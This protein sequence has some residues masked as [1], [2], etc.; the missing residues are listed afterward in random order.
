MQ[1]SSQ[2]TATFDAFCRPMKI[3]YPAP[4]VRSC[5]DVCV[6]YLKQHWTKLAV[7]IIGGVLAGFFAGAVSSRE[8]LPLNQVVYA[9]GTARN[10][11]APA[12]APLQKV[13][14]E[15]NPAE[16]ATEQEVSRLRAENQQLQALVDELQKDR[17]AAHSRR[18]K[19]HHRRRAGA[20]A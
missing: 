20:H 13:P 9:A 17:P 16:Q 10:A 4:T 19:T 11:N 14:A 8:Y 15:R 5:A 1:V 2:S 3:V 6:C 18:A 12:T 7:S